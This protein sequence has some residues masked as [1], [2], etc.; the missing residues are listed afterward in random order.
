M[1]DSSQPASFWN[2]RLKIHAF[3]TTAPEKIGG[4]NKNALSL[5]SFFLIVKTLNKFPILL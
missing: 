3:P 4:V 2:K 1:P 5:V